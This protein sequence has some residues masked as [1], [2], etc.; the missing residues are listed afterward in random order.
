MKKFLPYFGLI[1]KDLLTNL[2]GQLDEEGRIPQP[3]RG[4][5]SRLIQGVPR[6]LVF[7]SP[8]HCDQMVVRSALLPYMFILSYQFMFS[9]LT[10]TC[11]MRSHLVYLFNF[12]ITILLIS[13]L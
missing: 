1:Q 10:L 8:S 11:K 2:Y 12:C 13:P 4:L 5:F 9:I 3:G 6:L 7:G